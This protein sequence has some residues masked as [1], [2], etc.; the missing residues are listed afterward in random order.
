MAE[1]TEPPERFLPSLPSLPNRLA[2]LAFLDGA[3]APY[4][5]F[6]R[7]PNLHGIQ[8]PRLYD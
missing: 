7:E 2:R 1:I 4:E 8:S 3:C 5:A 6:I